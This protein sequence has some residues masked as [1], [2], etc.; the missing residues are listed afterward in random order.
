MCYQSAYKYSLQEI[1]GNNYPTLV[2]CDEIHELLTPTRFKF[3]EDNLNKSE[4][5][6]LGLSATIDSRTKYKTEAGEYIKTDLLDTFA[7]V[8]FRY[9]VKQG[10]EDETSRKLKIYVV[11]H[12]LSNAKTVLTGSKDKKFL[13]SEASNY[14]YLTREFKK[15]LFLPMSNKSRDFLIRNAASRRAKFLYNLP[16]KIEKCKQLLSQIPGR[17][18]V[19]GNS[20][21]SLLEITP[22]VIAGKV[23]NY[24]QILADFKAGKINTAA[25]FKI[26]EQGE[27]IP[28]LDNLVLLSYYG[29]TK[30]WVQRIGRLRQSNKIGRVYVFLTKDTQEEVWFRNMTEDTGV[31]IQLVEINKEGN[32]EIL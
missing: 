31:D 1:F 27:N 10:Q 30:A 2:V 9:T 6:V 24:E 20:V 12:E 14:E 28:D 4:V 3:A 18:L 11:R 8:C 26:L 25:A 32:I 19:F 29:K 21:D 7:P 13:V 5:F 17:T 15:S 23:K 16:S 22:N